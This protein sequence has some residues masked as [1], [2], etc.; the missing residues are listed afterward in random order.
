VEVFCINHRLLLAK[1]RAASYPVWVELG[2]GVATVC[3]RV[4][5]LTVAT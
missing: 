2:D 4:S 3:H 5:E 1:I